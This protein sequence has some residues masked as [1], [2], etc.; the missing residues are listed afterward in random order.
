MEGK[1]VLMRN[2][3]YIVLMVL[4]SQCAPMSSGDNSNRNSSPGIF[5]DRVIGPI[6]SFNVWTS[7]PWFRITDGPDITPVMLIVNQNNMACIVD[8]SV[9]AL[10]RQGE[11][12]KCP[13]GIRYP[14][15]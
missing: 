8:G 15:P 6:T 5:V 10:A 13:L 2:I 11:F 12:V 7:S 1:I 4:M 9:W 3:V 14:R